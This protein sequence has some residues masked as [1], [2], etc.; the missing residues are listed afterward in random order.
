MQSLDCDSQYRLAPVVFAS[1]PS[2]QGLSFP[3]AL[4]TYSGHQLARTNST[5]QA[6]GLSKVAQ[7]AKTAVAN[8]KL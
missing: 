7:R 8:T 6:K 4:I 5:P 1:S 3:P 2:L